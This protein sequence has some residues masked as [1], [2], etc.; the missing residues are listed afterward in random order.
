MQPVVLAPAATQAY[1]TASSLPRSM[2]NMPVVSSSMLPKVNMWCIWQKQYPAYGRHGRALLAVSVPVLM[3]NPSRRAAHDHLKPSAAVQADGASASMLCG[4]QNMSK[5]CSVW[6]RQTCRRQ[7]SGEA[8]ARRFGSLTPA[9]LEYSTQPYP[10]CWPPGASAR[11]AASGQKEHA[12]SVGCKYRQ[13]ASSK[14]QEYLQV[15][16][17]QQN[18]RREAHIAQSA[19]SVRCSSTNLSAHISKTCQPA[20]RCR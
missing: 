7:N 15:A 8:R 3:P 20:S 2:Q 18:E 6:P 11:H 12:A 4:V 19:A 16:V 10:T 14:Q 17:T 5:P 13:V 1:G 9:M